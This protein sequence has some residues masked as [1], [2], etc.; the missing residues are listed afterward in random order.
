MA[1]ALLTA[2]VPSYDT[3]KAS[4]DGETVRP[5]EDGYEFGIARWTPTAMLPAQYVVFPKTNEDIS[6]AIKFARA[7][8]TEIAV[9]C[10]GHSWSVSGH[11][12]TREVAEL[13]PRIIVRRVHHQ[14][15]DC[16]ST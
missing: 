6:K 4:L 10:G 5:G 16:S 7:I 12:I 13:I 15:E 9:C 11:P 8:N 14:R 1:S 2:A 3:F